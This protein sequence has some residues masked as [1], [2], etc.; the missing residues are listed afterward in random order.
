MWFRV[1]EEQIYVPY[2][3]RIKFVL[4]CKISF[5][6]SFFLQLHRTVFSCILEIQKILKLVASCTWISDSDVGNW[7]S[8]VSIRIL[9]EAG[10]IIYLKHNN[11]K[12]I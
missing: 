2:A 5:A 10:Y 8:S 7:Q 6:K 4:Q 12:I 1:G 3:L 11:Y 9:Q